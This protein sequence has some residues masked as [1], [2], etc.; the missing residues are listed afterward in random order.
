[1]ERT[2]RI[3]FLD[4]LR[5]LTI[6]LVIVLHGSMTYMAY[7]PP[8]WYVVDPQNSLFFTALVL[9]IDVPIM[10]IL[11]FVS[12]Y[13]AHPSLAK[14]GSLGFLKDKFIRIGLPWIFGVLILAPPTAYMIYFSRDVPVS[15][16]QFWGNEFWGPMYQQSVYWFLGILFLIFSILSLI[17]ALTG[18][19]HQLKRRVSLPS[20]K[21]FG[22][23][24]ALM[25]GGFLFMNLFFPLDTWTHTGYLFMFQPL[26]VPLYLGYF[27]LGMYAYQNSWFSAEGYKPSLLRWAPL[28][29]ISGLLYLGYR[30]VIPTPTQTTIILKTGNALLF[31]TFC[32]TSL[33]VGLA[34][35]QR[36]VNGNKPFWKSQARNSYGIYYVHPLFLYPLAL[37]FVPFSLSIFLKAILIIILAAFLSWGLS[38]LVL[39]RMPLLRRV[40]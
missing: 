12:G 36:Y 18:R 32:L 24:A 3:Y 23:F 33:M 29:A 34:F 7:A 27:G 40:F 39:T 38:A 19:F 11:L 10:L 35:F 6:F 14:R 37:I 31:N 9:L 5:A 26:R 4:N 22:L 16:F 8:W 28:W 21:L 17:Y 2:G 30:F 20:W 15:F 13:F 1:M 25:T